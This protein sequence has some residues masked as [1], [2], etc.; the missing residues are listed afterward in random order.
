MSC[1][2]TS[3]SKATFTPALNWQEAVKLKPELKVLYTTGRA[4][5]DGMRARF[6]PGSAVLTKPY[7][8]EELR[9]SLSNHFQIDPLRTDRR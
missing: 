2:Q 9:T 4:I 6:V 1:S 3:T 5:T 8:V 7:T